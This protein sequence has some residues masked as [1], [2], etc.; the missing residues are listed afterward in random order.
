MI[1]SSTLN[2]FLLAALILTLLLS[3]IV[4]SPW[5]R[6]RQVTSS[7]GTSSGAT[8]A[9]SLMNLNV[10]VFRERLS[11]LDADV[12]QGRLEPDEYTA[13]KTDLERQLLAAQSSTQISSAWPLLALR[14]PPQLVVALVFL[15][16]PLLAFSFYVWQLGGVAALLQT[17]S[18]KP[19]KNNALWSYWQA[20]DRYGAIAEQLMSGQSNTP[21]DD[22]LQHAVALLQALQTNAYQHPMAATRWVVLSEGYRAAEMAPAAEAALAHAHRLAPEDSGISM[23]YAQMRF[24]GHAGKMDD[25]TRDLLQQVLRREPDHEGALMLLAVASFRDQQYD[26]AV[27]WLQRLKAARLKRAGDQPVAPAL[28]AEL[29]QTI[30]KAQ[31]ASQDQFAAAQPIQDVKTRSLR[32]INTQPKLS[33]TVQ[34]APALQDKVK[35]SDT[36]FV[37]A[38]ALTGLSVPYAVQ[39]IPAAALLDA[40]RGHQPLVVTLT[41]ADHMLADR[42]LSTAAESSTSLVVAAR[43]STHGDPLPH[44]GDVESLPVPLSREAAVGS[45]VQ[46]QLDQIRP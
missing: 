19:S 15:W 18:S 11:E 40:S 7:L 27:L 1:A 25:I 16:L 32:A 44:A 45:R 20:Q 41:E 28:I 39:K 31:Q 12:G 9:I 43:I 42:T 34:L 21:P 38:R 37:Y 2:H 17:E 13:L 33:I 26:A 5:L 29:D 6:R 8:D 22:A 36:L 24:V 10:S 23:R 14:R 35:P 46:I 30:L 3:L 4:I